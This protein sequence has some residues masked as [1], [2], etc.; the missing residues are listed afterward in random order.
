[1]RFEDRLCEH[2]PPLRRYAR[3]LCRDASAADDLVQECL[4]RALR[5]RHLWRPSGRL[6]G[7]LFRMLYRLHLNER[8]LAVHRRETPSAEAGPEPGGLA[9][10]TAA[11]QEVRVLC[12]DV[13]AAVETLPEDQRAA[14]LLVALAALRYREAARILDVPVGT[15]RSR[16]ARARETV[17]QR[18]AWTH[19]DGAPARLRRVQ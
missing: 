8:G 7:W 12:S 15:L 11:S 4:L 2:I 16:L 10:A 19:P 5:K 9:A 1:V 3:A 6:R 14:L 13:L 18:S 17:R